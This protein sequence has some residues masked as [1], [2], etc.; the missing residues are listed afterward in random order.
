MKT[1]LGRCAHVGDS[2]SLF[3]RHNQRS[4][5]LI[6]GWSRGTTHSVQIDRLYPYCNT[7]LARGGSPWMHH[8]D[9]V[10][11]DSTGQWYS[12]PRH[13]CSLS[14]RGCGICSHWGT[15]KRPHAW[16]FANAHYH[17]LVA[18]TH[19]KSWTNLH[20]VYIADQIHLRWRVWYSVWPR[21]LVRHLSRSPKRCHATTR[22]HLRNRMVSSR[23]RS[24]R[25]WDYWFSCRST[26]LVC[27]MVMFHE[28]PP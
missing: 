27:A 12:Y 5:W 1:R 20:L 2:Q 22:H 16:R 21:H 8:Y 28:K 14:C 10:L 15:M 24:C 18:E 26:I 9:C 11:W 7:F 13:R 25:A 6:H 23:S 3:H 4:A 19:Q 17:R